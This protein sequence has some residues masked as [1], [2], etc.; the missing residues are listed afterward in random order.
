VEETYA[1]FLVLSIGAVSLFSFLSVAAWTDARR[2][3]REAYYKSEAIKKLAEMQG[4]VPDSVLQLIREALA[5]PN[6]KASKA[7]MMWDP[8]GY[9]RAQRNE[10]LLKMAATPGGTESALQ[11]LRE[12]D[13]I[14]T[15]RRREGLRLGGIIT[16]A[17]GVGLFV[18]LR[19]MIVEVPVYLVGLIP[20]LVGL[21]LVAYSFILEDKS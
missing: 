10:M 6:E 3:E 15:Q 12:E 1:T 9:R 19:A 21:I 16:A 11:Y 18:F 4:N 8:W 2:K 7:Q 13:R 20:I 17:V 5:A 14:A